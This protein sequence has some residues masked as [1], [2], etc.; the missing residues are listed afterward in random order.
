MAAIQD[1]VCVFRFMQQKQKL[2]KDH[3]FTVKE[4]VVVLLQDRY[5]GGGKK[6]N[7]VVTN[8]FTHTFS[9]NIFCNL[10]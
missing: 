6:K 7:H 8:H 9:I 2:R 10:T 3:G 5:F 4:Y 1:A